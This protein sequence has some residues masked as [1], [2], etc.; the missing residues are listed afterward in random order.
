MMNSKNIFTQENQLYEGILLGT[1]PNSSSSRK[2][3]NAKVLSGLWK[4]LHTKFMKNFH[5][6]HLILGGERYVFEFSILLDHSSFFKYI[7]LTRNFIF[8]G[9]NPWESPGNEYFML[10][11]CDVNRIN[12]IKGLL[13]HAFCR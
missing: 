12:N 13:I 2:I 5:R 10:H 9:Q 8:R 6:H 1:L 11:E 7:H 3:T 4:I